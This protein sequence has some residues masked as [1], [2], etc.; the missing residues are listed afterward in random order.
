VALLKFS[1][2]EN[3]L[4][5]Q[6][7]ETNCPIFKLLN[8]EISEETKYHILD[9][10]VPNGANIQFFSRYYCR[11]TIE[12][13]QEKLATMRKE[14]DLEK[15]E[16]HQRIATLFPY[17]KESHGHFDLILCWDALNYLKPAVFSAFMQHIS[18]FVR[19][20]TYL[21]AFISPKQTMPATPRDYQI[22]DEGRMS[23]TTSNL[24]IPSPSYHQPDLRELMPQFTIQRSVLLKN[25][26]QE[27]LFKR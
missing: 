13:G 16:I 11:L 2:V 20:G 8:S 6:V 26:M 24:S 4:E 3:Q 21:H 5:D 17:S 10:G 7:P 23:F 19:R 9:I 12:G 15:D 22:L 1:S 14:A 25:G 27:Y 18:Q